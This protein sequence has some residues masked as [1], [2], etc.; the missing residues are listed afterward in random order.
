MGSTEPSPG[1][2][3]PG[4]LTRLIAVGVR[5][6]AVVLGVT[7]LAALVGWF[8]MRSTPVDAIPDVSENQVIVFTE[9]AGRSPQDV[10]N[11]ITYPL[12]AQ[13][14]GVPGVREI[15]GLSGFGFSQI[16]VVFHDDVELYWAR[17]RTSERLRGVAG[18][19]PAGVVPELGPDAT[20]LGQ[21]FWYSLRAPGYDLGT[22]RSLQDWTLRYALQAVEG[23]AE[24]ASI[25][26]HVRQYQIDADPERLK[27]WDLTVDDL[28]RA[29]ARANVDIGAKTLERNGSE[30]VL[31]GLGS[32]RS[33]RDVESIVV[34][35]RRGVPVFVRH[36]AAVRL[37]PDFRR[38]ALADEQ[39]ERVGGVVTMRYG[40]NPREVIARVRAAVAAVQ[41]A[42]PE[43]VHIEPFYDRTQLVDETM[44]TLR[45]ALLLEIL[46]TV[47]VV[48]IFLLNLRS[49][50]VVSLTVP[51]AVLLAFAGM[52]WVGVDSNI[53]SLAGIAIAIG[54]MVD[55]GIV[56]TENIYQ[57]LQEPTADHGTTAGG[58]AASGGLSSS[59]RVARIAAAT[60][61]V[62]PAVL[63][64]VATTVVSFLPVFFLTGQAHKLFSPL[65][66]TKTFSLVAAAVLAVAVV[67]VLARLLLRDG[68]EQL[69]RRPWLRPV[70]TGVGAALGFAAGWMLPRWGVFT[71]W[72]PWWPALG[73]A[74]VLAAAA[75][76][77]AGEQ[78]VSLQA[79]PVSRGI[80]RVYAP[81]LRWVLAHKLRFALLPAAILVAGL[82]HFGGA[83]LFV[84]PW[85]AL[86]AGLGGD[87]SRVRPLA[88]LDA[89]LPP[90]GQAF[91]PPLDEG[92]LLAMPSLLHQA[93]PSQTLDV[94]MAM[95]RAI[96]E[97]PEVAQV[98]GKLGRARSAL[99]PAPVG[100][101]ET[102]VNLHPVERWR[103]GMTRERI[104]AELRDKT[105]IPGIS[106][107]WLQ[108]IETRIVML[109][110]GLRASLALEIIG[111][112]AGPDG[113]P[114]TDREAHAAIEALAIE[115]EPIVRSVRGA[116]DVSALRLG[117]KPYLEL[118]VDRERAG[119]WGVG[120]E[121]LLRT[122]EVALGG[123]NLSFSLEGR[124]RYPIRVQYARELYDE[125]AE[126]A[127][128]LVPTRSGVP[129]P[130]G[131]LVDIREVLGP[132]S[133]R[134]RNGQLT[135]Y[136][137]FN[138]RDRDEASVMEDALAA[139]RRWRG[140]A[141]AAGAPD[142]VPRGLRIGPAGRYLDKLQADRRLALLLPVVL[143]VNVLLLF[144][145]FRKVGLTL[146][147]FSAIPITF[148]GGFVGLW[149]YPLL[150]S[151]GPVY[152]TTAVWV[153]FIAL[154]GIAVDDGAVMATYLQQSFARSRPTTVEGVRAAV[155]QAGLRRI[156]PCLMTTFTTILALIPILWSSG[157]GS[158]VMQP[159]ALP[160]VGGMVAELVTLFVV[161]AVYSGLEERRVRR[162]AAS[163]PA[164]S[165]PPL[166]SSTHHKCASGR[167]DEP[168]PTGEA[169]RAA[170]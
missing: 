84:K 162:S 41:R 83:R 72:Q 125:P 100:M 154:F 164:A 78:L 16:Y 139:V 11:Q 48:G 50:V 150:S 73:G 116:V 4:A 97:V 44:A 40:E 25:G 13:L 12:S 169:P 146:A 86:V 99:D 105:S 34:A 114:F 9:W 10:E 52:R 37:G 151:G 138:A 46:I 152:L 143:L 101:I 31:R 127:R 115:L 90:I 148:A 102:V 94:M 117:G 142:P 63:V 33:L 76:R 124:E 1:A 118:E 56:I 14:Q 132:A 140:A 45:D 54:T 19:V 77:G 58:A 87:P 5:N 43:G 8:A 21:V 155:L 15:R 29:V 135:G 159:M 55:M 51:L 113:A 133:V 156:R 81:A 20:P 64:A 92:S 6:P 106:P 61:E 62:A 167:S 96:R 38:G 17:T 49:S 131:R 165:E 24:V 42:L 149:V 145:A 107:S 111:A 85:S 69:A 137:M 67:P 170:Q 68:R 53:M 126:L 80:H 66:W 110:S 59:E 166:R 91:M 168:S 122:L 160:L 60:G 141:K 93:S 120:T 109:Q 88:A 26:G 95:N 130:L 104:V 28:Q 22:L 157:R 128:L 2:G 134:T 98:M 158:D 47:L 108:P 39:G 30:L 74:L 144:A 36:V 32:I 18:L 70:L 27:V 136:V 112:P 129:I 35:T 153:G 89:A 23:V 161:P 119:R 103:P 7:A 121:D 163:P 82:L 3:A 147:V 65:A 75:W 123:R 79:N 57:R 71:A